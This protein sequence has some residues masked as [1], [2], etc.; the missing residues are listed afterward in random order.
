MSS[1][2][3]WEYK[4]E[5]GQYVCTVRDLRG[6]YDKSMKDFIPTNTV[7]VITERRHGWD[8]NVYTIRFI[9]KYEEF[10][11]LPVAEQDLKID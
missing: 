5:I 11:V 1:E 2:Y 4:Y 9:G 3:D 8:A 7:G 10:G 6:W